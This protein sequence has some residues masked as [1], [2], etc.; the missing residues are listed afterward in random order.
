MSQIQDK[1]NQLIE[2]RET[3]RMGG[4]QKAIDKQHD[5]ASTRPA[6]ASKCSSTKVRSRS[7]TCS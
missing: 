5:K 7:S 1:I 3:A 2:N 4:G 6:N